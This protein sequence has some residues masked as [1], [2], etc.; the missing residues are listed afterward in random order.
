[1]KYVISVAFAVLVLGCSGKTQENAELKTQLD[2]VSYCIGLDIGKNLQRQSVEVNPNVLAR[3]IGDVASGKTALLTDEQVHATLTAFQQQV[4]EQQQ[5]KMKAAG[6][7]ARQEG[8]KFLAENKKEKGVTTLPSG[9]QYKV[10]T[11]GTGPK[12]KAEQTVKVHYKGT[13]IDGTEF[14]S[15]YKRGEPTVY[16]VNGFV[17]GWIEA[18]QLM[19]VGSKWQLFVPS[20]LAYGEA[21]AGQVI[22]PNATLIFEIELLSIEK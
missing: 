13:L 19:P 2:S 15:S 20:D 18:L 1:M 10:L 11:M 16:P 3:G 5:E 21:G 6:E 22:P 8:E 4:R 9:L 12:P 17:K 7:K 14:D